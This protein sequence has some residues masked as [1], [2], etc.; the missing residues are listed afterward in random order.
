[1]HTE[2]AISGVPVCASL[3][4]PAHRT[5][6]DLPLSFGTNSGGAN[7][8]SNIAY[9]FSSFVFVQSLALPSGAS[10]IAA[11]LDVDA[12]AKSKSAGW[13]RGGRRARTR[14]SRRSR[15]MQRQFGSCLLHHE[16][17][18]PMRRGRGRLLLLLEGL[19]RTAGG[20]YA[21]HGCT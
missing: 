11:L 8:E 1:M 20:D 12:L 13:Q 21:V 19:G 17:I 16:G 4:H 14:P 3:R 7:S 10:A 18:V 5:V 6:P 15:A 2:I 9:L